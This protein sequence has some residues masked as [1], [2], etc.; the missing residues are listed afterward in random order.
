MTVVIH[1]AVFCLRY[2]TP[3]RWC[4]TPNVASKFCKTNQQDHKMISKLYSWQVSIFL[5][6][7]VAMTTI[8]NM[9]FFIKMC[10]ENRVFPFYTNYNRYYHHLWQSVRYSPRYHLCK[11]VCNSTTD[12]YEFSR[13]SCFCGYLLFWKLFTR[14]HRKSTTKLHSVCMLAGYIDISRAVPHN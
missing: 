3:N 14:K 11:I 8:Q 9:S 5:T 10:E 12:N 1:H 13:Y 6:I 2:S 7:P 4:I